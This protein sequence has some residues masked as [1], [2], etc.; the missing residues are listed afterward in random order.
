MIS[1]QG[2]NSAI[3]QADRITRMV[4]SVYPHISESKSRKAVSHQLQYG[5]LETKDQYRFSD[6]TLRN[7]MK[8]D[9]LRYR[10]GFGIDLFENIIDMLK[11]NKIGNCYEK[12]ILSQIIGKINGIKNIYPAKIYCT[13]NSSG[14]MVQLD[15]V[16]SVITD[17]PLGACGKYS[18]KNKDAV[19]LDPWLGITE[20][21][22][23]YFAKLRTNFANLFSGID[24]NEFNLRFLV[25]TSKNLAEF[26][27]KRKECFKQE[28]F[29]QLHEDELLSDKDA[30][31]LRDKYPELI[32]QK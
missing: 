28:F 18:Y 3:R 14:A 11:N 29:L 23:D 26:N 2:R 21:A 30:K 4:N 16:V 1:F 10:G 13:K 7:S 20:F 5:S 32:M 15:H 8:L 17:I 27:Q 25:K 9:N 6:L 24:D 31:I 22:G 12:S 19:I